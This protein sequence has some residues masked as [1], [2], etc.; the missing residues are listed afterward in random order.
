MVIGVAVYKFDRLR[1]DAQ[2]YYTRWPIC[3][4][5]KVM[6]GFPCSTKGKITSR[7][8][9]HPTHLWSSQPTHLSPEA[10]LPQL[11]SETNTLTIPTPSPPGLAYTQDPSLLKRRSW[12]HQAQA[13][14]GSQLRTCPT[15]TT[16]QRPK[17]PPTP[18]G[19]NLLVPLCSAERLGQSQGCISSCVCPKV[20]HH[21]EMEMRVIQ[22]NVDGY[23][24]LNMTLTVHHCAKIHQ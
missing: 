14:R 16:H 1:Y 24:K 7:I 2:W 21:V 8:P 22:V 3:D 13:N 20:L 11:P 6:K 4:P 23:T 12:W 5:F 9:I 10:S 15:K 18:P 19:V 17:P